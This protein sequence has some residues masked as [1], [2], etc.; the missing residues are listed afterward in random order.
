MMQQRGG[1]AGQQQ[2][3][4]QQPPRRRGSRTTEDAPFANSS[5]RGAAVDSFQD[6]EAQL[7][8][9]TRS[10][11]VSKMNMRGCHRVE[12]VPS[13]QNASTKGTSGKATGRTSKDP[14]RHCVCS[15]GKTEVSSIGL[16]HENDKSDMS[17]LHLLL[18]L[19]HIHVVGTYM[20][21]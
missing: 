16:E 4:Q 19:V 21:M 18:L 8:Q 14:V 9:P 5:N 3:Q 10:D 1:G 17:D 7:M 13:P 6:A 2:Q 11:S 20:Y 12:V 15:S